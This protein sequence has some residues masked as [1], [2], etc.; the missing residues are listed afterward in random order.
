MLDRSWA[1]LRLA[2]ALA[3]LI[4]GTGIG[5]YYGV[6]LPARAERED[7]RVA[8]AQEAERKAADAARTALAKRQQAAQQ[9]YADCLNFAELSYRNRWNSACRAQNMA[10]QNAFADCRDDWFATDEGC[11]VKHPVRPERDCALPDQLAATLGSDRDRAR[12][13]CL[14]KLQASGAGAPNS[15]T[16]MPDP[17]PTPRDGGDV[18][19]N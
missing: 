10:D 14:G 18:D 19:V 6:V 4:A 3:L 15:A 7:A 8:K 5:Y 9:D 2:A 1:I 11:R 13:Q 17:L 16:T 12:A